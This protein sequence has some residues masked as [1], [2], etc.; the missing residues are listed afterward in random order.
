M[1]KIQQ[2]VDL[3]SGKLLRL[4]FRNGTENDSQYLTQKGFCVQADDL[5]L[6]DL[7]YYKLTHWAR[8]D[9][10]GGYF[11]TRYKVGTQLWVQDNPPSAEQ[12]SAEQPSAE[13]PSAEQPSYKQ[14]DWDTILD[15][16]TKNSQK[17][18]S[19]KDLNATLSHSTSYSLEE[20]VYLQVDKK[21]LPLRIHLQLLPQQVHQRRLNQYRLKEGNRSKKQKPYAT[22]VLKK[23]LAAYN[24]FLTNAADLS[25][26]SICQLY[27][28][29]WQVEILFKIW[30]SIFALNQVGKMSLA[31]F[32]CYLYGKFISILL[33]NHIQTLFSSFVN[34]QNTNNQNTNNQ[35]TNNQNTNNQ[36]TNNQNTNNQNTNNQNTNNQNTNNQNKANQAD[37]PITHPG[38]NTVFELS[39]WKAYQV[40]NKKLKGLWICLRNDLK[41]LKDWFTHVF[42]QLFHL[43]KKERRR[44]DCNGF[45]LSPKQILFP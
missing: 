5:Q 18:R 40:L 33:S 24:I 12:P 1:I 9:Q 3:L 20:Q 23:R 19:Q 31:R 11:I 30:K 21:M 35:N 10:Q 7:G 2:E 6:M 8:I 41:G 29:R 28:L 42:E 36:N 15:K 34:N 13:Q 27:T 32:E 44:V 26:E 38:S 16:L 37:P 4:D 14:L 45:R 39:E 43:A 22:S 17:D 25:T